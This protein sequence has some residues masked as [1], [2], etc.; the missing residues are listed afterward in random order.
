MPIIL[1]EEAE[2]KWGA[3]TCLDQLQEEA[4]ELVAAISHYRRGREG[5]AEELIEEL[6]DVA[7]TLSYG[8]HILGREKVEKKRAEKLI[9]LCERLGIGE[10]GNRDET[11]A[12]E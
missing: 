8:F 1:E 12:G 7:I 6:A 4:G 3:Q 10:K 9:R 11:P 5:A 2:R